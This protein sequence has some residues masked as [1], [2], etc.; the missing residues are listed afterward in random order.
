MGA[1]L[2]AILKRNFNMSDS[3]REL[4]TE[5][6]LAWHQQEIAKAKEQVRNN[7]IE[8][9]QVNQKGQFEEDSTGNVCWYLDDLIETLKERES[10]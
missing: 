4:V 2:Q 3:Y 7:I 5:E 1:E 6:I 10:S 8:D 9:V